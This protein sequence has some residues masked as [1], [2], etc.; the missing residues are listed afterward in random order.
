M[1]KW[2]NSLKRYIIIITTLVLVGTSVI[3]MPSDNNHYNQEAKS[4]IG[5]ADRASVED[6]GDNWENNGESLIQ[7][8]E[9]GEYYS[10]DE[11]NNSTET[12][13]LAEEINYDNEG[14]ADDNTDITYISD[15]VSEVEDTS[16]I[17]NLLADTWN[18]DN[19]TQS[20]DITTEAAS[21][22]TEDRFGMKRLV[23]L[24]EELY[25]DY[26]AAQ[27]LHFGEYDEYVLQFD[28][29]EAAEAAYY[30]IV[31]LYGEE[32]CFPDEIVTE[33]A[34]WETY[35]DEYSYDAEAYSDTI[36]TITDIT[37]GSYDTWGAAYM[38]MDY[39]KA[40]MEYADIDRK[41]KIAIIDSGVDESHSKFDGR[42]DYSTS[43]YIFKE[44]DVAAS[45]YDFY[46]GLGHGTHVS[47][48]IADCTPEI[49]KLMEIKTFDDNGNSSVLAITTAMQYAIENNAD[50]INMSL[51][52]FND[53]A[54]NYTFL[55]TIITKAKSNGIV[56]C[57][58][59][60]NQAGD[61]VYAY[62]AHNK[63][64]FTVTA[65]TSSGYFASSYSNYGS[66]VDFCA[67]GTSIYNTYTN[68]TYVK[69]S[70]TSMATPH[71]TSAVAYI[72]LAEPGLTVDEVENRL[73][74]YAVDL[75]DA[76]WDEKY[77]Y[78]CINLHEYFNDLK[79]PV[80]DIP[81]ATS[82]DAEDNPEYPE[83]K[84]Q[85]HSLVKEYLDTGVSNKLITNSDGTITYSSS[86]TSVATVDSAGNITIKGKGSCKITA[87]VSE[88]EN[89][90]AA[91]LS[92]NITVTPK[93][94][95][96]CYIDMPS[97]TYYYTGLAIKPSVKIKSTA[98]SS[99]YIS[100]ENYTVAYDSNISL[101]TG[102][103]SII[104]KGNC[105]GEAFATFT[106]TLASTSISSLA[107]SAKGISI[108]WNKV[109]GATG[110]IVYRKTATGTWARL[111]VISGINNISYVDTTAVSGISYYYLVRPVN[112]STLGGFGNYLLIK[113]LSQPSFTRVN[114]ASG[115]YLS[116]GKVN[117][118]SGYMIYRKA[119]NAASWTLIKTVSSSVLSY[120]DTAVSIGN[121][122]TY[123]IKAYSGS[124]Y[125]SWHPGAS[126]YRM[127]GRAVYYGTNYSAG[128]LYL[129][130]YSDNYV[131][132]YQ[133]A[134]STVSTFSSFKYVT[135]PGNKINYVTLSNLTKGRYYYI[136]VR[137]YRTVNGVTYCS[138]WG[139]TY[140][141]YISK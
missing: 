62:P 100:S 57:A 120:T 136:K 25:D 49:V 108:K 24:A 106:I 83:M 15:I 39:L 31:D 87:I 20:E 112:G 82:G 37:V 107:N 32:S 134:Y 97:Y 42:I 72:M 86:N 61:V 75:G 27:I 88:T 68:G 92:Y 56:I 128:K 44:N 74:E 103:I 8:E 22:N 117:G 51:G 45:N 111:K 64:V 14:T 121:K 89:Y 41:V 52:W 135:I 96:G 132:G 1:W 63:D 58:A 5:D 90:Q 4:D 35:D 12:Q 116:W 38:G 138:N 46:D 133:V 48:I 55:D 18:T 26:D 109:A 17:M 139:N 50:V 6:N 10:S 118:V 84:F 71:V 125:S 101:G 33:D 127:T 102:I 81:T 77:G 65:I 43:C 137:S 140:K 66:V 114:I 99:S 93:D 131:T 80:K 110:Y 40:Q 16:D 23:L 59:A 53:N 122:Y 85:Y 105:T 73:K 123:T 19:E 141:V 119:N 3:F 126:M 76:G 124:Y 104:G 78:G 70:G 115:I 28:T 30:E 129:K 29:E 79:I 69:A 130:W 94:L 9:L 34:L 95:S 21:G 7:D 54:A 11:L 13:Y 113:R 60:G 67:P 47:G 91:S 2:K 98:A 36:D